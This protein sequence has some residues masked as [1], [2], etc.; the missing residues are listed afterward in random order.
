MHPENKV[1]ANY[2]MESLHHTVLRSSAT[3]IEQ[4]CLLR[5]VSL[6]NTCGAL[7]LLGALVAADIVDIQ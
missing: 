3:A 2:I 7:Y 5:P 4:H 1:T 6:E